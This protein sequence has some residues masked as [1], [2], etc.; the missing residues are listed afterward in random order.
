LHERWKKKN[1]EKDFKNVG[2]TIAKCY[3]NFTD[4]E[5]GLSFV[6]TNTNSEHVLSDVLEL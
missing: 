3:P 2:N 6:I 4:V 5:C 1:V